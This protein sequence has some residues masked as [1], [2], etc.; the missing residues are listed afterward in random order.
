[1]D[2]K[3]LTDNRFEE[4][5]IPLE[6]SDM[7]PYKKLIKYD[8]I[9]F[10]GMNTKF[11][12]RIQRSGREWGLFF[13]R[14]G[15]VYGRVGCSP[16][17]GSTVYACGRTEEEAVKVAKNIILVMTYFIA[18]INLY[19]ESSDT[20]LIRKMACLQRGSHPKTFNYIYGHYCPVKVLK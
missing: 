12:L 11:L 15:E 1:M 7:V 4:M 3:T 8:G 20:N 2:R 6:P 13:L 9:N 18:R 14:S 19:I 17:L 10:D 5:F 16:K